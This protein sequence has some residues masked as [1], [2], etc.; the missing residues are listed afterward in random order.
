MSLLGV[1]KDNKLNWSH[2]ISAVRSK[3]SKYLGAMYNIKSRLPLQT[4]VQIYQ[5]FI[6][7]HLNYCSLIWGFAA[8]SYI[9]SL[10]S[11]QKQGMRAIMPDYVNYWYDN[12]ELPAHTK[13][14]FKKH[15]ILTVHGIITMN[16]DKIKALSSLF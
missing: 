7:S 1:I 6:H 12:G 15:E 9:E 16:T 8:K 4:R 14:S 2:L 3:M 11:K 13:S 10:F 5:S